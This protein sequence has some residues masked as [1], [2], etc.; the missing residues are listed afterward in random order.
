MHRTDKKEKPL[1]GF[2]PGISCS[3]GR[4]L[5]HWAIRALLTRERQQTQSIQIGH[6]GHHENKTK[7]LWSEPQTLP[8]K[9]KEGPLEKKEKNPCTQNTK[10][11]KRYFGGTGIRARVRRITT[12]YANHYTIP[13]SSISISMATVADYAVTLSD[14]EWTDSKKPQ[15]PSGK[16]TAS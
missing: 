9:K 5:I 16:A 2:E 10:Y 15:W 1:P 4:R 7:G 14:Q 13:P 11:Q 3:V 12:V 8:K 6:D